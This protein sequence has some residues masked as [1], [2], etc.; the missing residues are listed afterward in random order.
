MQIVNKAITIALQENSNYEKALTVAIDAH[1]MATQR[2]TNVAPELL[3][4][5][6]TRRRHIPTL[7][8]PN[9]NI[10]MEELRKRDSEAKAKTRNHE[11]IKRRA[12]PTAIKKGDEV[13]L[14]RHA[15]LKDQTP[16]EPTRFKII[17]GENGNFTIQGEDGR[18]F[19]RNVVQ[20][21]KIPKQWDHEHNETHSD[22]QENRPKRARRAPN[23]LTL[24]VNTEN[25]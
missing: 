10:D 15:K 19:K 13:F 8:K 25:E 4:F 16:F 23:R 6:R 24:A 18:K 1:N 2:T 3:L 5:G 12:K 17:S 21:K 11:N 9:V 20:L 7:T 22:K 14:K